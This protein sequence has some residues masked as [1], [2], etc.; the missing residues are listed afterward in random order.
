[1][2]FGV[3]ARRS[4][5]AAERW[6]TGALLPGGLAERVGRPAGAAGRIPGRFS[7]SLR[8]PEGSTLLCRRTAGQLGLPFRSPEGFTFSCSGTAGWFCR[9]PRSVGG[10]TFLR[11]RTAVPSDRCART[12]HE[13][14]SKEVFGDEHVG[15]VR[16]DNESWRARSSQIIIVH[17][18]EGFAFWENAGFTP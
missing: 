18:F 16:A 8:S 4:L 1:M 12:L 15:H 5:P 9:S 6:R 14:V 2:G 7:R 17:V 13:D 10:G 3:S 11:R